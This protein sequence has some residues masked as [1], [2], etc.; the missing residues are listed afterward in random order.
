MVGEAEAAVERQKAYID[1]LRLP[2]SGIL[3]R[4]FAAGTQHTIG[5]LLCILTGHD[6]QR[7]F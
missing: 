2:D 4:S 6:S 1:R 7:T 3:S 5:L